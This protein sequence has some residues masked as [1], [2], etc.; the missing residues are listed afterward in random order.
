VGLGLFNN[1]IPLLSILD[2]RSPTNN[3]HIL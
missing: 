3:F 1:S 2:L